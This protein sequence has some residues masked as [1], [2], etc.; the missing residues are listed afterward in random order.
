MQG[1]GTSIFG[2]LAKRFMDIYSGRTNSESD[3]DIV[4]WSNALAA[5]INAL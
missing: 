5:L 4:W 3:P 1:G 2:G